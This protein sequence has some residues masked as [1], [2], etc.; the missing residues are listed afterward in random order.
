MREARQS[1]LELRGAGH[2]PTLEAIII[3]QCGLVLVQMIENEVGGA[4]VVVV[5]ERGEVAIA[6][7]MQIMLAG[8]LLVFGQ[9]EFVADA[10]QRPQE[11]PGAA[12]PVDFDHAVEVSA[13]DDQIPV[14]VHDDGIEMDIIHIDFRVG[15]GEVGRAFCLVRDGHA[16]Q[17]G[18][19]GAEPVKHHLAMVDFLNVGGNQQRL[20][21]VLNRLAGVDVHVGDVVRLDLEIRHDDVM[22]LAEH[23]E[24]V[25]VQRGVA[26]VLFRGDGP[27]AGDFVVVFIHDHALAWIVAGEHDC[28]RMTFG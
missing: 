21:R 8:G 12:V 18:M 10:G 16:V 24:L 26:L 17:F 1:G 11:V 9:A 15:V 4:V 14:V 6:V 23:E 25:S 19:V 3:D 27:D 5:V 2:D 7:I 20:V 22:L 28:V 13:G